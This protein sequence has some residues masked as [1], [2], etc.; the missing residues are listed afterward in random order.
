MTLAFDFH[1][2]ARAEFVADVEWYD[3]RE[4][5]LG[6]RFEVAVR[7]AIDAAVDTPEAWA[8]W[9]AWDRLIDLAKDTTTWCTGHRPTVGLA[10]VVTLPPRS[11]RSVR[12]SSSPIGR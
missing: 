10:L 11:G 9:Q 1:P 6:E 3:A 5:G 7:D 2:E 12:T 4:V 8:V